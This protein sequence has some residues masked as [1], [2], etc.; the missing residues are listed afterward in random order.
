MSWRCL[1]CWS[2]RHLYQN[3]YIC[4]GHTSARRLEVFK[5]LCYLQSEKTWVVVLQ[6]LYM[7]GKK[8][9]LHRIVGRINILSKYTI[10]FFSFLRVVFAD[11]LLCYLQ[12]LQL[13][14]V[15]QVLNNFHCVVL[16]H[17]WAQKLCLRFSNW[18]YNYFC[19]SRSFFNRYIQLK[20]CF[21]AV[22]SDTHFSR[23]VIEN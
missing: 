9:H 10:Y 15:K 19:P 13:L 16:L 23:E 6:N 12:K 5:V 2:S 14:L 21:S 1:L 18:R 3:E 11:P 17:L 22:K 7:F 8:Y 20:R 4:F